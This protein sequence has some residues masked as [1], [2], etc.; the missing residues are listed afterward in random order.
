MSFKVLFFSLLVLVVG[1]ASASQSFQEN[2]ITK[3]EK[4]VE[5]ETK[6]IVEVKAKDVAEV[7]TKDV[8]EE[9]AKEVVGMKTKDV[10]EEEAK[11]KII[12]VKT[13]VL[14]T[15][16]SKKVCYD[17]AKLKLDKERSREGLKELQNQPSSPRIPES[18]RT[19]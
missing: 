8:D 17:P 10:G 18:G 12:C 5:Q 2:K 13:K 7:K 11:D 6:D 4:I 14:G 16:I 15:R 19:P 3:E 9:E 1:N